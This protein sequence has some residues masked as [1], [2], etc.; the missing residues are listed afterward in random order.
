MNLTPPPMRNILIFDGGDYVETRSLK[1]SPCPD[2]RP[3]ATYRGLLHPLVGDDRIELD[4][5]AYVPGSD[6]VAVTS[7]PARIRPVV[8][9]GERTGYVLLAGTV[10]EREL[11]ARAVAAAGGVVV[12]TGRYL[13]DPLSDFMPDWLVRFSLGSSSFD[14]VERAVGEALG[15]PEPAAAES[16]D[17]LRLTLLSAEL[18][19][20]R[21]EAAALRLENAR[22]KVEKA[23]AVAARDYADLAAAQALATERA[24]FLAA[25]ESERVARTEA[26]RIASALPAETGL[27]RPGRKWLTSEVEDVIAALFPRLRFLRD[28]LLTVSMEFRDRRAFYRAIKS[29]DVDRFP[30]DSPSWKKV[31]GLDHWWER[32]VSDGTGDAGRLYARRMRAEGYVE[33]L[34]SVKGEQTRDLAWMRDN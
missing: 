27:P 1:L 8:I 7:A 15:A 12:R 9:R 19:A 14:A 4:G 16:F 5:A 18:S 31:Q 10:L 25:L 3:G 26:E 28:G 29:I 34:A 17:D 11:V 21:A 24:E 6:D 30:A 20:S 33:V 2:G 22:L 23:E 32:H 13:G